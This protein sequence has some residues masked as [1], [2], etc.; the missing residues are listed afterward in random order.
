MTKTKANKQKAKTKC[1]NHIIK[2]KKR[3]T[4]IFHSYLTF[5]ALVLLKIYFSLE[6]KEMNCYLSGLYAD[7][8]GRARG[9]NSDSETWTMQSL[10]NQVPVTKVIDVPFPLS[11]LESGRQCLRDSMT[12]IQGSLFIT[13]TQHS[14]TYRCLLTR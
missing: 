12:W 2:K 9:D 6:E 4:V 7:S 11:Q 1:S 14:V 3:T 8:Q 10:N 13:V 5:D